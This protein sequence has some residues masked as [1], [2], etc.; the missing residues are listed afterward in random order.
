MKHVIT[1]AG[2]DPSGGAG[3]QADL[4]TMHSFGMNGLSAVTAVT[5][6]GKDGV[7]GVYVVPAGFVIKQ[8]SVLLAS[9]TID[10]AKIGMLFSEDTVSALVNLLGKGSLKNVVLDPVMVS[11]SGSALLEDGG[12]EALKELISVVSVVTP[13]MHEASVLAGMD[14]KGE[15][16]MELAAMRISTLGP[17]YVLVKGGHLEGKAV[18]I[19]Y[20]GVRFT[21]F[22]SERIERTLHGTGCILSSAIASC[23]AKGESCEGAVKKAKDYVA[24]RIAGYADTASEPAQAVGSDPQIGFRARNQS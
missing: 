12:L 10:A 18:D 4:R 17:A 16:D 9:Y 15:E 3:I 19:L 11:S 20:D 5:A 13:N 14:V 1:I 7:E 2:S 6:Q 23:L 21:R 24:A 22:E 8:I